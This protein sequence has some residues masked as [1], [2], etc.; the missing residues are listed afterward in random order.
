MLPELRSLISVSHHELVA[1]FDFRN[2][3]K[4]GSLTLGDNK[5]VTAPFFNSL[6]LYEISLVFKNQLMA[7]PYAFNL[8]WLLDFNVAYNPLIK[9]SKVLA[10]KGLTS[11]IYINI[12]ADTPACEKNQAVQPN[13]TRVLIFQYLE[14]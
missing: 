2:L 10:I 14:C 3:P 13:N 5:W 1:L 8:P 6:S 7:L 12:D 9:L 11:D 4:L